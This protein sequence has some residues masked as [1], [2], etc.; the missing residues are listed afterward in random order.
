MELNDNQAALILEADEEG[1]IS[2]NVSAPDPNGI[3]GALCQ[4]LAIKLTSDGD[5]QSELV[6]MLEG[7]NEEE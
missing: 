4:A 7:D 1:E 6:K 5:L 3:S 2:V